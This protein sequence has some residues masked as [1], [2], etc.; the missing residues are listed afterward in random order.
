LLKRRVMFLKRWVMFRRNITSA[1]ADLTLCSDCNLCCQ[2]VW[3]L[4]ASRTKGL[5]GYRRRDLS[6]KGRPPQKKVAH[7]K[8]KVD[9]CLRERDSRKGLILTASFVIFVISVKVSIT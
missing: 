1:L 9:S 8:R 3:N 4:I 5:V 2:T 6:A 7:L